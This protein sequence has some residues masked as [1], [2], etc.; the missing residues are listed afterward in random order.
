MSNQ[1]KRLTHILG[2]LL[3]SNWALAEL[4]RAQQTKVKPV[5]QL[6]VVDARGKTVGTAIGAIGLNNMEIEGASSLSI[7]TVVL[8]QMEE[9]LVPVAVGKNGFYGGG[10]LYYQ[11]DNCDTAPWFPVTTSASEPSTLLPRVAVGP[12]G[13]TVYVQKPDSTAQ[14]ITIRSIW[15]PPLPCHNQTFNNVSALPTESLADLSKEFTPPF[16]LKAVP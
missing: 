14:S 16:S 4:G 12:P 7:R 13:Q 10:I 3:I 9:T 8:L 15:Q 6:R 5:Q 2:I 11:S 1:F